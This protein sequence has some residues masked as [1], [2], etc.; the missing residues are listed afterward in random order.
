[1]PYGAPAACLCLSDVDLPAISFCDILGFSPC[2]GLNAAT[3]LSLA[4]LDLS[5]P[6]VN[7]SASG[8]DPGVRPF[9][10]VSGVVPERPPLNPICCAFDFTV[11]G[12]AFLLIPTLVSLAIPSIRSDQCAYVMPGIMDPPR[13]LISSM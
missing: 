10:N 11:A 4:I 2:L 9:L 12:D 6:G 1:M 7:G 3:F 5:A 13:F 8:P